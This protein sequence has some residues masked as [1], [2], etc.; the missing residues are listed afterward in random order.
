MAS[1][2]SDIEVGNDE[3]QSKGGLSSPKEDKYQ[4]KEESSSTSIPLTSSRASKLIFCF[5]GLQFSYVLW[6]IVQENLMTKEYKLGKFK[7]SNFCVFANRFLALIISLVIVGSKRLYYYLQLRNKSKDSSNIKP[8]KE[9]PFYYYAPSS[10]SNTLSSWAQ[11]ESLKYVS[12]PTQVLS[13]SCK[14]IP[15]MLV[16]SS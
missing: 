6:G 1:K 12:F 11:Y 7:S 10:I 16:R 5:L 2:H 15:V 9:A 13:K 14:I 8:I 3:S 4:K